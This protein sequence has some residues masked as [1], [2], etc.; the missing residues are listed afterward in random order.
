LSI[1]VVTDVHLP[2]QTVL[3]KSKTLLTDSDGLPPE[4]IVPTVGLNSAPRSPCRA[5]RAALGSYASALVG[6]IVVDGMELLFWDLGGQV[7][8]RRSVIIAGA[9]V[10]PT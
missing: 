3:E 5:P 2:S 6:K 1:F 7:S 8:L 4:K 10:Q 9:R